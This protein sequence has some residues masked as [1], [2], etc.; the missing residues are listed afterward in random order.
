MAP[1]AGQ[2]PH[3]LPPDPQTS[4]AEPLLVVTDLDRARRAEQLL[5]A[6]ATHQLALDRGLQPLPRLRGQG[7]LHPRR[8]RH[9][10]IYLEG[11]VDQRPVLLTLNRILRARLDRFAHEGHRPGIERL[12]AAEPKPAGAED[13]RP[14][15]GSFDGPTSTVVAQPE[16]PPVREGDVDLDVVCSPVRGDGL[17]PDARQSYCAT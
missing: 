15:V 3:A 5:V 8:H 11:E 16:D 17:N 7:A 13:G 6:C 4:A 12:D 10:G 14:A 9:R 2:F 1:K